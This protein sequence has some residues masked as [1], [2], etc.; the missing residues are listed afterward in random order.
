MQ[1]EVGQIVQLKRGNTPMQII[2]II[3]TP[4][5]MSKIIAKYCHSYTVMIGDFLNPACASATYTRDADQFIHWRGDM[6]KYAMNRDL[7]DLIQKYIRWR[8]DTRMSSLIST[9]DFKTYQKLTTAFE[10]RQP[11]MICDAPTPKQYMLK[12]VRGAVTAVIGDHIATTRDGHFVLEMSNG[13]VNVVHPG[14]LQSYEPKTHKVIH[15]VS[16]KP[17]SAYSC[18]YSVPLDSTLKED[19]LIMS[20]TGNIY[21]VLMTDVQRSVNIKAPFKG[22]KIVTEDL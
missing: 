8:V 14:D 15:V 3:D 19:D 7:V 1:F 21:R 13:T 17:R 10:Q 9:E 4:N 18:Y 16:A 12:R 20:D 5:R 22:K 6:P 11:Q 2:K